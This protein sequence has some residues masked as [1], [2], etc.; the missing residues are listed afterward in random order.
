MTIL[1]GA[2]AGVAF[3]ATIAIFA[4]VR[5]KGVPHGSKMEESRSDVDGVVLASPNPLFNTERL[6]PGVPRNFDS[7]AFISPGSFEAAPKS[8][9]HFT[10]WTFNEM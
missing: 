3:V 5:K 6:V 8:K 7:D 10:E 9:K 4:I 2:G 1:I